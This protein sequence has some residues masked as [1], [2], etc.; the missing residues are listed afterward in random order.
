VFVAE[1]C[2]AER[3]SGGG[4]ASQ[5]IEEKAVAVGRE[6]DEL[7]R[8]GRLRREAID[9]PGFLLV[10]VERCIEGAE[11]GWCRVVDTVC[12]GREEEE[13]WRVDVAGRDVEVSVVLV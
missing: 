7:G 8:L 4:S 11:T 12:T 6:R 3:D 5:I 10:G 13:S 2:R 9:K 1:R